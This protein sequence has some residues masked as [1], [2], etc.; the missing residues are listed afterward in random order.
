MD[1]MLLD[2]GC[3]TCISFDYFDCKISGIEPSKKMVQEYMKRSMKKPEVIIA[4][5]EDVLKYFDQ[6]SF[7]YIISI[8]AAH[9][10]SNTRVTWVDISLLG[11]PDAIFAF[12]LLKN[13]SNT[14]VI[15][16]VFKELFDVIARLDDDKDII[17]I[18]KLKKQKVFIV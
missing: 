4:P 13:A 3:G 18:M 16:A 6:G 12:S 14:K 8:T 1:D 15:I 11:K 2:V 5:A 17:F 7:D 9:H 10:F